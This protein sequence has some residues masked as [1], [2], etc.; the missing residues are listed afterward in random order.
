MKNLFA[1]WSVI[2]IISSCTTSKRVKYGEMTKQPTVE[3]ID[4]SKII[5]QT[6]NSEANS[7]LFISKIKYEIDT[8]NKEINLIGYQ[9]MWKLQSNKFEIKIRKQSKS[10]LESYRYFWIDPDNKK[11]LIDKI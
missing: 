5:V 3:I 7:S 2:L 9:S 1:I 11:T 8:K 4:N 10:Q 6:T